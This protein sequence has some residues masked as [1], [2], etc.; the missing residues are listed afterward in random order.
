MPGR[1]E[2]I[3]IAPRKG[4]PAR[5]CEYVEAIE[6]VGL[7]GDR[8]TDPRNQDP[9]EESQVTLIEVE[10]IEAFNAST[11]LAMRTD[12]PRRNLVT[13]GIALNDLVGKRF[14]VGEAI[15]EGRELCEPCGLF[16]RNTYRQ[17]VRAFVHK[18]GLRARIVQGGGI[19][20]GDPVGEE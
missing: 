3:F 18:G 20:V 10:H 13:R 6:G 14:R 17:A 12:G 7:E 4:A 15:L 8:Y 9:R 11:G 16:G 19:R 2:Q 1:I 5:A